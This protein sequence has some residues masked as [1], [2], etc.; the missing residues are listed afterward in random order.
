VEVIGSGKH[1]RLLRYGNNYCRKKFYSTGP[2]LSLFKA[3]INYG[4][5]QFYNVWPWQPILTL[6]LYKKRLV[7]IINPSL[8]LKIILY[9]TLTLQQIEVE[10][11]EIIYK[12]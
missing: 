6:T 8:L 4:R 2:W 12:R 5:E 11:N 1:S 9:N 3:M 7:S 10:S